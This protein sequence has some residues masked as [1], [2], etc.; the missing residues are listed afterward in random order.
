MRSVLKY[1]LLFNILDTVNSTAAQYIDTVC[2]NT[3]GRGYHVFG[4]P[5]SNFTWTVPGG[6]PALVND[7]ESIFADRGSI[8]GVYP[9]T[10]L[11]YSIDGC[12]NPF[13]LDFII[14]ND[15]RL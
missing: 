1:L 6:T 3:L 13:V 8:P 2:T 9:M 4:L 10:V 11:E 15:Y 14:M 5:G 12:D 7:D